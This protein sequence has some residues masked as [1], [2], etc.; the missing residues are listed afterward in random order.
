M[1]I[2]LTCR[3][4]P[5]YNATPMYLE[6]KK[7]HFRVISRLITAVFALQIVF[8]GFCLMMPEAYAMPMQ[9]SHIDAPCAN[10]AH[11][12]DHQA[13]DHSGNCFHCD[14]PDVLANATVTTLT[15]IAVLLPGIISEPVPVSF[16]QR[17]LN[18]LL[19]S[20]TPTGPP[21]SS[22]LLYTTSQRIRI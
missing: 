1:M 17:P 10:A 18:G 20:R 4:S 8:T 13:S 21:R 15:H 19:S 16:L 2:S 5:L 6:H 3:F 9:S 14:Q 22:T 7:L 12:H 11:M